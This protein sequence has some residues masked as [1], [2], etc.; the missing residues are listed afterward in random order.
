MYW[1]CNIKAVRL[2]LIFFL[3]RLL[4]QVFIQKQL[5]GNYAIVKSWTIHVLFIWLNLYQRKSSTLTVTNIIY[6]P[7]SRRRQ[8]VT[9][10]SSDAVPVFVCLEIDRHKTFRNIYF[11]ILR[12]FFFTTFILHKKKQTNKQPLLSMHS[13]KVPNWS[14]QMMAK[15]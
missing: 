15:E 10:N 9:V 11:V 6:I 5:T 7:R 2:L 8:T 4:S 13:T 3:L 1:N 14:Q 12:V